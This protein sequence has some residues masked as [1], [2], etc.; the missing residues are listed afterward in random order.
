MTSSF[1]AAVTPALSYLPARRRVL[2]EANQI[3]SLILRQSHQSS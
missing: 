1:F 2:E 3:S